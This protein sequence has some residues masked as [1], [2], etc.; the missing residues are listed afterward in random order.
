MFYGWVYIY[1]NSLSL[2]TPCCW[3]IVN[4][5]LA[6]PF[7][8]ILLWANFTLLCYLQSLNL[9][10]KIAACILCTFMTVLHHQKYSA[11]GQ[12]YIAASSVLS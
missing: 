10:S 4:L 8:I 7:K 3:P 5:S 6:L 12:L 2:K 11:A 1:Y 9:F